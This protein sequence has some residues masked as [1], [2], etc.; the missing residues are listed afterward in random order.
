ML[1][2]PDAR[3]VLVLL[4]LCV[5]LWLPRLRGSID[6]R[7]DAGVYYIQGT[8]LAEGKGYRLLNEPGEIQGVQYPPLLSALVAAHQ[9]V[10]GT[11]DHA[12]VGPWLRYS[13]F[14][15]CTLYVLAAYVLARCYLAAPHALLVG[16]ICAL[17]FQSI[18]LS[19][20]LFAEIPFALMSTL[21]VI[22]NRRSTKAPYFVLT[23]LA[24]TAAY[25]LRS[26]G[27]AL[28]A[29][30]VV[31]SIIKRDWKQLALRAVVSAIPVIAWQAYIY[32]VTSS[33]EYRHPAYRYQRAPYQFN[34]VTYGENLLLVDPFK[35]EEGRL[36]LAGLAERACGNLVSMPTVLGEGMTADD[37]FWDGALKVVQAWVGVAPPLWVVLIP[38]AA[39][40]CLVGAGAVLLAYRREWFIPLYLAAS[41]GLICLTGWPEQFSRYLV[42]LTPLLG[43]CLIRSLLTIGENACR[44]WSGKGQRMTRVSFALVMVMIFGAALATDVYAYWLGHHEV[45]RPPG[46]EGAGGS[47]LFYYDHKWTAF[48]KALAWLQTQ[49]APDGA[50][51]TSAPHWVYLKTRRKAVFMPMEADAETANKYLHGVPGLRYLIV[52]DLDFLDVARRYAQP[53]VDKYPQ[54]WRLVYGARDGHTRV[55]KRVR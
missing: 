44:R 48:D 28:L 29:A 53:V 5:L 4:G 9:I 12:V 51:A 11:N 52:D 14:V 55:Y 20:L 17:N 40:G 38:V 37:R 6:L 26:T 8:A 50:V 19:N 16:L 7:Y 31:E 30:W 47:L 46:H 21:F 32:S 10:L 3:C 41:G 42:P 25:L 43:L 23:A 34:N 54:E 35:P 15:I 2:R 18:F 33:E 45:Y 24:G 13:Y 27:L 1:R 49:A 39:L 36:S 22:L